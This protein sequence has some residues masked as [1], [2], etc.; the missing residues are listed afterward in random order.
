MVWE[1]W[2]QG[3]PESSAGGKNIWI[4]IS[5]LLQ[6]FFG[7]FSESLISSL[8]RFPICKISVHYAVRRGFSAPRRAASHRVERMSEASW[9]ALCF[10]VLSQVQNFL[11]W[12]VLRKAEL[13]RLTEVSTPLHRCYRVTAPLAI[14]PNLKGICKLSLA[15]MKV[16]LPC[17]GN[18]GTWRV[19][20][21]FSFPK[22]WCCQVPVPPVCGALQSWPVMD[23]AG[24]QPEAGQAALL[25]AAGLLAGVGWAP[26]QNWATV[27]SE[28]H[29]SGLPKANS[30]AFLLLAL[31]SRELYSALLP[32]GCHD[33]TCAWL[34]WEPRAH[35][36]CAREMVHAWKKE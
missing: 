22:D 20:A 9:L 11:W 15:V 35:V 8:L 2:S 17:L 30:K 3:C 28:S 31:Q 10:P 19:W 13:K 24:G 14:Q 18:A 29:L 34:Q 25:L 33:Q 21:S 1:E 36:L 16:D 27:S 23:L 26:S 4:Q 6:I 32:H 12:L 7:T 5:A